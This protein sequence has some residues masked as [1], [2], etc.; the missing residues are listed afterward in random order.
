MTKVENPEHWST[1]ESLSAYWERDNGF[2]E[3]Y[4]NGKEASLANW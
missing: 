3:S 2:I 4:S 1:D